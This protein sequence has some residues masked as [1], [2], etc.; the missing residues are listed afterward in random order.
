MDLIKLSKD[1]LLRKAIEL[2]NFDMHF[3]PF[4]ANASEEGSRRML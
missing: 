4:S 1:V 2:Q 3:Q